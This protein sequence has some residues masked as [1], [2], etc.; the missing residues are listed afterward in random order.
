MVNRRVIAAALSVFATALTFGRAVAGP[1]SLRFSHP[2]VVDHERAGG[3]PTV[4]A[5][6]SGTLLLATHAGNTHYWK[7]AQEQPDSAFYGHHKGQ[8]FVWRSEDTGK[9]WTPV[10]LPVDGS[11]FSDPDLTI[12]AA[13]NIYESEI[14]L[15]NVTVAKSSDAGLTWEANPAS[16]IFTDRE[17]MAADRPNEVFMSGN[18]IFT[19]KPPS[20]E[21]LVNHL[22][23]GYALHVIQRTTDGGRT[24]TVQGIDEIG[25]RA[26]T[27][28]VIDHTDRTLYEAYA[29]P[30]GG[31][32]FE[33]GASVSSD[34]GVTWEHRPVAGVPHYFGLTVPTIALDRA[35]NV[36]LVYQS[37]ETDGTTHFWF[38]A[39]K[40]KGLH[41]TKPYHLYG[42]GSGFFPWITAGDAGRVGIAWFC[43]PS[44]IADL[45]ATP[46][47]Y[48]I[49]AAV[50]TN[51]TSEVPDFDVV[52]ATN[53][54]VHVSNV[55]QRG[56]E[57]VVTGADRRLGDFLTTAIDN[58]GS[59]MIAYA[60][61]RSH[62]NSAVSRPAFI[63]QTSG[64]LLYAPA[65]RP[66]HRSPDVLGKRTTRSGELP[67][68][69]VAT[70]DQA[71]T[72]LVGAVSLAALLRRRPSAA[73]P[74]R[75]RAG[76]DS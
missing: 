14:N 45:Q 40:D 19:T 35:G 12:D 71:L 21:V 72:A 51:A 7:S 32:A 17:W 2:V 59:L 5:H 76:H 34:E 70:R 36:Y 63:R 73:R 43:T 38:T 41:W 47:T 29:M 60:E 58:D 49:C 22:T 13:G 64:P 50:S 9:T 75:H 56:T 74:G 20:P 18:A 46:G 28:L 65:P 23:N 42:T 44:P 4:I 10:D 39:S 69:G 33:V 55:C 37:S 68:T 25:D 27:K 26:P 54:P 16:M 52:T 1:T 6:P 57:C 8:T 31:S 61:T 48:R 24:W 11:G 67:Q 15:A 53:Q 30:L 66:S 62:P 3:E